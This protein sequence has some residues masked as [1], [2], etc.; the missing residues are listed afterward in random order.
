MKKIHKVVVA[1]DKE[2]KYSLYCGRT[3]LSWHQHEIV[4][5]DDIDKV[6]CN[7]CIKGI[8]RTL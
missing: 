6:T 8:L 1:A 4:M 2:G 7:P 3:Y 5:T